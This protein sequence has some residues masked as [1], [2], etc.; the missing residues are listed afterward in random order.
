[1]SICMFSDCLKFKLILNQIYYLFMLVFTT[2]LSA[3]LDLVLRLPN[4]Q[5]KEEDSTESIFDLLNKIIGDL[6]T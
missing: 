6:S 1:M 4:Q 3:F 5:R 2:L